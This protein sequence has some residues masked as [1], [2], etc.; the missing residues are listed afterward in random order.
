MKGS[1]LAVFV[2]CLFRNWVMK[3]LFVSCVNKCGLQSYE[4]NSVGNERCGLQSYELNSVCVNLQSGN[5]HS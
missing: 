4:L 2:G 3:V 5:G 1:A